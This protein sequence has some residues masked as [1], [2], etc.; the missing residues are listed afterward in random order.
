MKLPLNVPQCFLDDAL[1]ADQRRLVRRWLPATV[2][3]KPVIEPDRPWEG[4][5]LT[6]FGTVLPE[7]EGGWRMYYS[8]FEPGV[9]HPKVL[10]ATSTDGFRWEKPGLGLVE[11]E[12]TSANNIV[13]TPDRHNDSLSVALDPEDPQRPYKLI[14]F[15]KG[16][17]QEY[18]AGDSGLH[19]Y[20]SPDGLRWIRSPG[21]RLKAGDRTNLMACRSNGRFVIYTRHPD[22]WERVGARA[23]YRSESEDFLTWSEPELVLAPDLDD[24]PDIE[25]YGMSVFERNGWYLGLLEYWDR[26]TDVI[27]VHLVLSRDGRNW[28]PPTPREPF[29]AASFDWNRKWSSCASNGPV[30]INE[31]MVFYFGG[32]WTSHGYDSAQQY[33]AIGY[34]SL[35]LDRFCAVEAS[36]GGQLTTVPLEWPNADLVLNADT[37]EAFTSHPMACDGE[38]RVEVLDAE[39]RPLPEWSGGDTPVFRGNTHCRGRVLD[40]TVRWP[41]DRSLRALAGHTIRLR[42]SLI[43]A[44]LFTVEARE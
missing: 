32:R 11:W 39:G 9:T 16:D 15:E 33:G 2:F 19:A 40:G 43:H 24:E 23:I 35:P 31:Q 6:L 18:W 8:T 37:R 12:G 28:S 21:V 4:R 14:L 42:F 27:Q 17:T 36:G 7:P 41:G 1:I 20:Q 26:T 22:M 29:I 5:M 3:P 38:I 44:R 13:L 30:V 34:A 25:Y 10:L